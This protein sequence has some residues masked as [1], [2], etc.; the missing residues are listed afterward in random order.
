MGLR[1]SKRNPPIP[2]KPGAVGIED[3]VEHPRPCILNEDFPILRRPPT[4][5]ARCRNNIM[6]VQFENKHVCQ[7]E[8]IT[9][10][11]SCRPLLDN[12][13]AWQCSHVTNSALESQV[14]KAT[15]WAAAEGLHST[16][17]QMSLS[18]SH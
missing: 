11:T 15:A 6:L 3:Q 8:E 1:G 2:P 17:L 10:Y 4:W 12:S 18:S 7:G 13:Q 14:S 5:E 9:V 16:E